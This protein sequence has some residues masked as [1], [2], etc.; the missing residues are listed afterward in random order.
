MI[1]SFA[2]L[3]L[4][5]MCLSSCAQAPK[6]SGSFR[7]MSYNIEWFSEDANPGRI[8]NL[9]QILTKLSP[10]IIGVQEVQS[11]KALQQIF[12]ADQYEIAL[13]DDPKE[14]QE[15]GVVVRKPMK[16]VKW[17]MLFPGAELDD[18]FP[19]KRDVIKATVKLADGK[20]VSVYSFHAKS[21]RGGRWVNDKQRIAA[22]RLFSAYLQNRPDEVS[23]VCGDFND[24][25]DDAS[26]NVY[27]NGTNDT[28]PGTVTP[29]NPLMMNLMEPLYRKDTVTLDLDRLF[30]GQDLEPVV[31]GAYQENEKWRGKEHKFPD[32]LKVTQTCFDQILV[33]A[34]KANWF[35]G[36]INVY[37][38]AET[39]RGSDHRIQFSP[40]GES[41]NYTE[42]GTRASDHLPVYA[43]FKSPA[44]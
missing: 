16:I 10:D 32:D 5:S 15:I 8:A 37:A 20:E 34:S 38:G 28:T 22:A 19:G 27:E 4:L 43:D 12:P 42:K 25:P 3:A 29:K 24:T 39:M 17:E 33:R 21:R 6:P 18:A 26:M 9:N 13:L 14:N 44:N 23:I 1:R 2:L 7:V 40:D 11:K 30:R 31:P 35:T 36:Q 41:V